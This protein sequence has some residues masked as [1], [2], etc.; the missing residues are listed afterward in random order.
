MNT[1]S[2]NYTL[3]YEIDFAQ[4]YRWTKCKKCF[5]IKTG[6]QIKQVYNNGCIGYNINGKFYSL[7]KL[8]KHIQKIKNIDCPF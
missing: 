3:I 4:N 1:I 8:K 5:N 2:V 7:Y 6:R